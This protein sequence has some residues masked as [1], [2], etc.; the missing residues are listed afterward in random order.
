M[1]HDKSIALLDCFGVSKTLSNGVFK[2]GTT[3]AT[4]KNNDFVIKIKCITNYNKKCTR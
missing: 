3:L 1:L 2:G 4:S